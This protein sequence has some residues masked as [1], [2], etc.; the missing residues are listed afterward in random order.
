MHLHRAEKI[1]LA[2]G[3]GMLVL[4]LLLA[5]VSAFAYGL[6]TPGSE[7]GAHDST[8]RQTAQNVEPQVKQIGEREYEVSIVSY[9]FGY[10]PEKL[11]IPAGSTVHFTVTSSDVVHGFAIP[12]TNVNIMAVPGEVN[13]FTQTFKNPGKYLILCNEYCGAGHEY[14]QTTLIVK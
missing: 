10:K 12:G 1:W 9:I 6:G 7:T 3:I 4:F 2:L 5:G 8:H 14:M 13:H 11:E